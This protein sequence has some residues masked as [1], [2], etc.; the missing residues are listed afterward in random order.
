ML[1]YLFIISILIILYLA[2]NKII[3]PLG[4]ISIRKDNLSPQE[5]DQENEE[6]LVK[7]EEEDDD[8]AASQ[9]TPQQLLLHHSRR[10]GSDD[11]IC[12]SR[13][14]IWVPEITKTQNIAT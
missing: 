4:P 11:K 12:R 3:E 1:K 2:R 13:F 5:S 9:C 6:A 8:E 7:I 10:Q 14:F